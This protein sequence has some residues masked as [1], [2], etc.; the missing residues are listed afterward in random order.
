M[1]G[2]ICSPPGC[3]RVNLFVLLT[4]ASLNSEG[5]NEMETLK[6]YVL[7]MS[8]LI[9]RPLTTDNLAISVAFRDTDGKHITVDNKQIIV[10]LIS[11]I[12][13]EL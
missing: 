11:A 2:I 10:N 1:V 7:P 6:I 4:P 5:T 9:W 8:Q 13:L 3:N 12:F